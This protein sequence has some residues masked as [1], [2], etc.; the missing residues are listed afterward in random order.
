MREV[1]NVP[2][3]QNST[4]TV[5]LKTSLMSNFNFI[6]QNNQQ[7]KSDVCKIVVLMSQFYAWKHWALYRPGSFGRYHAQM[8]NNTSPNGLSWAV[9]W[10]GIVSVLHTKPCKCVRFGLE[11][12]CPRDMVW[13]QIMTCFTKT[14]H[15]IKSAFELFLLFFFFLGLILCY[16]FPFLPCYYVT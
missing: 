3:R 2:V 16:F 1:W 14:G 12:K 11:S 10:A 9:V 6:Y 8:L 15:A 13:F 4:G 7:W 5:F